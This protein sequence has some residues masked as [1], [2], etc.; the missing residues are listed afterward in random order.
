MQQ[1][2]PLGVKNSEMPVLT[3]NN[4]S[5]SQ[6]SCQAASLGKSSIRGILHALS[7]EAVAPRNTSCQPYISIKQIKI[8]HQTSQN[9]TPEKTNRNSVLLRFPNAVLRKHASLSWSIINFEYGVDKSQYPQATMMKP[10]CS[11]SPGFMCPACLLSCLNCFGDRNKIQIHTL[12]LET[13]CPA[14]C[15]L[16]KFRAVRLGKHFPQER[17]VSPSAALQNPDHRCDGNVLKCWKHK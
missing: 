9:M 2:L 6:G 11:R 10:S 15:A 13:P 5:L 3:L 16:G 17:A 7:L 8:N 4:L 12:P 14:P 1:V